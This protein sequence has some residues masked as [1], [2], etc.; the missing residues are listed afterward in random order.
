MKSQL[1]IVEKRAI[2]S[3]NLQNRLNINK[4]LG[5][6]D[7]TKW[8][9]SKYQINKNDRILELGCGVGNHVVKQSKIVGNKGLILATD[10]SK[11]SL[12]ILKKNNKK[13]NVRIKC[14]SMDEV[15][16]FLKS[17]KLKF[18]KIISSYALYYSKNPIKVISECSE[19]LNKNGK[20]LITAPCYPHTLT[21]FALHQNTLPKIAK[22]YIDFSSKNLE[23]YLKKKK[24]K[25]KILNFRNFLKFKNYDDLIIFYRSTI[26]YNKKSE[27]SLR[28]IFFREKKRLGYFN[29]IKSAK[30]YIFKKN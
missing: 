18:D 8:L 24:I 17:K 13:N 21:E 20:F 25:T 10:Y 7:L 12:K 2:S 29:I 5:S 6:K 19:F 11:K 9:F 15:S 3:K 23:V 22:K 14:I 16:K 1:S 4:K 26:F 28:K 27:N 30:L